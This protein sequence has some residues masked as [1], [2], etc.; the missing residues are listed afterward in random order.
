MFRLPLI[1]SEELDRVIA[2]YFGAIPLVL[3]LGLIAAALEGVGIGLIIPL[4]TVMLG[5]GATQM[6]AGPAAFLNLGAALPAEGRGAFLVGGILLLILLKNLVTYGNSL[7]SASIYGRASFAIRSQLA[8]RLTQV[9]YPFFLDQKPGRLLNIL[10]NESWRASDAIQTSIGVLVSAAAA[11]ILTGFLLLLSWEMTLGVAAGLV[12]LQLVHAVLSKR[13]RALSQQVS[14]L[15]GGL[16]ARML[17]LIHAGRL[18]RIFGRQA[19]EHQAFDQTSGAVRRAV[20]AL[21]AQRAALPPLMEVLQSAL[22]LAIV[23]FAWARGVPFVVVAAFLVL[24]YRLQPQVRAVQASLAQLRAW[25]GSID[26]VSWLL[27]RRGKPAGPAGALPFQELKDAVVFERVTVRYGD[28]Q[29]RPALD[30][31]DL[32]I[33]AGRAT[34]LIGRSGSGKTTLVHLLCRFLEPDAGR[35]LV[36][37]VPLDEIEA[38]AW[39]ARI[40]VASQDLELIDGDV[41]ENIRYGL[42]DASEAMVRRAAR[43][44]DADDFIQALPQGYASPVGYRG[45]SLSAGQR[46]RISLARALIRDPEILILDEATNALDALSEAAIVRTLR[47]RAGRRTTLVV[48]H[49]LGTIGFCD[50]VVVLR[51]GRVATAGV[52]RDLAPAAMETLYAFGNDAAPAAKLS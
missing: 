34:A 47:S 28:V 24:L 39:N 31:V 22:F 18:I 10:S 5:G 6:G 44:A 51:E 1:K 40:A 14:R 3:G 27:D 25:T 8:E 11:L 19:W 42:L 50:D 33:A 48:S 16:A 36:D 26:E 32:R 29:E 23:V 9:G 21:E 43:L 38:A 45:A 12:G 52:L 20:F 15:N 37:G 41:A 2:P 13:L 35:V 4:L 17:H 30:A 7:V 49:H 46:Q